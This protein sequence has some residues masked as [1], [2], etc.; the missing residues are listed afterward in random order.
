M[1]SIPPYALLQLRAEKQESDRPP[2]A[3]PDAAPAPAQASAEGS[4]E[5]VSPRRTR[6]P[7][8]LVPFVLALALTG[9]AR[10][11]EP[12]PV[13]PVQPAGV[14]FV[15]TA[16]SSCAESCSPLDAS[17]TASEIAGAQTLSCRCVRLST[18]SPGPKVRRARKVEVARR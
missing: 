7:A 1:R 10:E 12:R 2:L 15:V 3:E 8:Y 18:L 6:L 14:P 5:A 16:A 11:G 9:C 13:Q 4:R 17:W